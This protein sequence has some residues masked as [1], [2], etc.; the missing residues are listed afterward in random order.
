MAADLPVFVGVD[1]SAHSVGAAMWAARE[2]DLL[3]A[4]ELR[5]VMASS[6][7]LRDDEVWETVSAVVDRLVSS[8]PRLEISP[9]VVHGYPADVLVR[10]S[11]EA[12]LLVVGARGHSSLSA[13]LI[14]S[15]STKVAMHAHC[16]VV[17]R[18]HRD[19]GPVA[20][21]LDNSRH[22]RAALAFAFDAAARHAAGLVA[23]HVWRDV[24]Y[25]PSVPALSLEMTEV[26]EEAQRVLVR[27]LAGWTEQYPEVPVREVVQCGHPVAE[28]AA[29][30]VDARLLV[31]GHRGR[32]EFPGL[33]GSVAAGVIQHASC[34][35]AVVRGECR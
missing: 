22:S 3:R 16:P 11:N 5:L 24:G 6:D 4:P 31:V 14:G 7:P 10:R 26:R 12:Q 28:L 2:A 20:V 35:V 23:V 21:G 32:G 1:G 15:V 34:P 8:H 30:S 29:A 25:V 17:V 33:L 9:E 19:S 18:D 27:Q 13:I